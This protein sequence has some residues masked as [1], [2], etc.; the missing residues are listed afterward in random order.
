[1]LDDNNSHIS[2]RGAA[3]L[4]GLSLADLRW[5]SRRAGLGQVQPESNG[6]QFVFTYDELAKLSAIS[7][8]SA[9]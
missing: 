7:A 5:F 2:E 1:M 9:D 3:I 6:S 8:P 4:L